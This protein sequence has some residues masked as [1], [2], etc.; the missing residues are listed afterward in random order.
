MFPSTLIESGVI[1][2]L[3]RSPIPAI[4]KL[5]LEE[6]EGVVVIQ[7]KVTSYY[8]KQLAQEAIKPALGKRRLLNRVEVVPAA[9]Q[10]QP[11]A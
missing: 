8:I 11:V 6:S 7:G 1:L 4:R 9:E 2:A 5:E 3:Q 10:T